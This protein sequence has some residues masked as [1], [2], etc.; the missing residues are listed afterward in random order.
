MNSEFT[1]RFRDEGHLKAHAAHFAVPLDTAMGWVRAQLSARPRQGWA[2]FDFSAPRVTGVSGLRRI[3]PWTKGDFW[4]PRKGRTIVSHLVVGRKTST[5]NL[6]VW[7]YWESE[8]TFILHTL[9]PGRRAP[10]EIHD[11]ELAR[12]EVADAVRFWSRH[13]IVVAPGEWEE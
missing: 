11:P 2:H 5:R 1:I 10:R 9:Y 3:R 6:C 13:A 12:T 7:G 8:E 4:A